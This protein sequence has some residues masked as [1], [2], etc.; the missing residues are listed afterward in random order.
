[1][2]EFKLEH[3]ELDSDGLAAAVG[4]AIPV[5]RV[6]ALVGKRQHDAFI[7]RETGQTPK[8]AT[9]DRLIHVA[10]AAAATWHFDPAA[11]T[12]SLVHGGQ[13]GVET[14]DLPARPGEPREMTALQALSALQ[15][16]PAATRGML[17][18]DAE[19]FFEDPVNCRDEDFALLRAI[20]SFARAGLPGRTLALRC[21]RSASI[22]GV[23]LNSP[24]VQVINIAVA[25][26]DDRLDYA[27]I[28]TRKLA[29]SREWEPEKL[30][31][32]IA[33]ATDGFTL[34]QVGGLVAAIQAQPGIR[35]LV[36]VDEL[37]RAVRMGASKSPWVGDEL[38]R[39]TADAEE[40]LGRRV[41]G[42]PQAVSAVSAI[43]RN[44][45]VGL[46]AAHQSRAAT[47]PKG[48]FFLAGPTGTGKTE[49]SKALAALLFGSETAL[50]R[51]DCGELRQ[52]HAV[53]RL[54][55]SPPGYV[56]YEQGG[57]LTDAVRAKPCSVILMDEIEKAH[58]RLL[59]TFLGVLDDG[60]LTSGQGQTAYFSQTII[61]FTSNLGLY[62]DTPVGRRPRF[63][64][65]TPFEEIQKAVRDGIRHEFTATLGRPELLGRFGGQDNIVVFD[66]LRDLE[67]VT[68]KFCSNIGERCLRLHGLQLT[69]AQEVIDHVVAT[70]KATPEALVLGG[71]GLS[72]VLERVLTTP[73][74]EW[75]F[76][77][78][79]RKP[80]RVLA[81]L[82][83]E[84]V[85]RLSV[86]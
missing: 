83:P 71:R 62:E 28:R 8:Q 45:V 86:A 6:L 23:L 36:D 75:L 38:R 9:L 24:A 20:E 58:P 19:L 7:M 60:R 72:S 31:G 37:A 44:A 66:Y 22:P 79:S 34:Q 74:G 30:A 85:T 54:I 51:F 26:R 67:G 84:G 69:V 76:K 4:V 41:K 39:L 61:I 25:G 35:H 56:G 47:S 68:R 59:D 48:V 63:D 32:V 49:L 14:G 43:L 2:A 12:V 52:E 40:I 21:A 55:G 33:A 27:R 81:T 42:Q 57:Q 46:T 15:R 50:I 5:A 29:E 80:E 11:G 13:N 82:G 17:L 1:M 3:I 77:Q 53:A 70:V 65:D 64:Y 73:L 18:M 16:L 78:G 10:A